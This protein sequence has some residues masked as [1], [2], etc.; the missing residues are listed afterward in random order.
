MTLHDRFLSVVFLALTAITVLGL[1]GTHALA[2]DVVCVQCKNPDL[3]YRCN[4]LRP[5]GSRAQAAFQYFCIKEL[6]K[7]GAHQSCSV[8]RNGGDV[9]EGLEKTLVYGGTVPSRPVNSGV[10]GESSVD[11]DGLADVGPPAVRTPDGGPAEAGDSEP[12]TLIE[13][14]DQAAEDTKKQLKKTGTAIGGAAKKTGDTVVGAVKKTGATVGSAV[15]KTGKV[16]GSAAKK[17]GKVVGGAVKKTGTAI[18]GAA[19]ST[20]NCVTS[21]FSNCF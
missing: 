17:T 5:D 7:E 13:L 16:V 2:D 9:C 8:K 3:T 12:K 4:V 1:A 19:K 20:L 10:A 6:A 18:G 21:L 15:K 11:A 14:T